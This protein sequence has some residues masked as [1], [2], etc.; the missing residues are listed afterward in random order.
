MV[1]NT[2]TKIN[3]GYLEYTDKY[4][5]RT[6][7]ILKAEGINPL[8]RYQV[9]ARKGGEIKGLDEAV[10]FIKEVAGERA[11][12]YALKDGQIYAPCEPLIK[13]EGRVQD[14]VE[15]ETVYLG[16]IAGGL[17]G[18]INLN[19]VRARAKDIIRAAQKKPVFYMGARH[20]HYE[21]DEQIAKICQEEGFAGA[22]TDIGAKAWNKEGFGTTPHALVIAY[23]AYMDQNKIIG[24]P[25]VE[26]AKG[27]NKNIDKK[28]PRIMLIDTFNREITDTIET[29]KAVP[30]LRGV[31]IDTCGENYAQGVIKRIGGKGVTIEAVWALREA[32][33]KNGF[34]KLEQTVSSGFNA[35]KTTA[36]IEAD[37]L[38]NE[39]YGYPLFTN[40]GTG[41]IA[42]PVMATADIVAYYNE[43]K[44]KWIEMH[45]VGRPEFP[46]N[47]LQ[48]I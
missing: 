22:S 42:K 39:K 9:F 19:E 4:F 40:I 27:F 29:A 3:E 38:F 7:Q 46:T 2:I 45:K 37:T 44:E 14:L 43:A 31:R 11:R 24:N 18:K 48:E 5:Q 32:L 36:F 35:E 15:L 17:T 23:A 10:E 13:I 34:G 41:S 25:T 6:K 20:F 12:V 1:N 30:E 33:V 26:A 8:V 21:L 16:M 28:I 47:R